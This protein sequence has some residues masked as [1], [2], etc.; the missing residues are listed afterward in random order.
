MGFLLIRE[1]KKKAGR[2][3]RVVVLVRDKCPKTFGDHFAF[4]EPYNLDNLLF[5]WKYA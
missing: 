1:K 5:M 4:V 2:I 3:L